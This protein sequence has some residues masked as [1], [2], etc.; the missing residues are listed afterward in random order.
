MQLQALGELFARLDELSASTTHTARAID[1]QREAIEVARDTGDM[2]TESFALG[3]LGRLAERFGELE[4]GLAYTRLAVDRAEKSGTLDGLYRWQWQAARLLEALDQSSRALAA[5][6]QAI[7]TLELVRPALARG[8]AGSFQKEVAP[9]FFGMADLLLKDHEKAPHGVDAQTNL[10]QVRNTVER[11]KVAEIRDY[12]AEDCVIA[13]EEAATLD[14]VSPDA[15]VV[16]PIL[17]DDR[18]EILTSYGEQI[19]RHS[20]A[21]SRAELT[22]AVNAF[23]RSLVLRNQQT[24]RET[25]Q[26]LY[27]LLLGQQIAAL[28]EAGVDTLIFVPDGPLRTVPPAA[29]WDGKRFLI[30]DFAVATTLGLTLTSPQP[31]VSESATILAGGLTQSVEGFSALPAVAN[32]LDR[33][34]SLFPGVEFRDEQFRI[35]PVTQQLSEG[36]YSIVHIATH[37]KF[38]SDYRDSFL[39][40]FDGRMTMDMLESSVGLRRYLNDPVELLMLSACET[41]VGDERAALG[42]AGVALKAGAR[43][44]IATLWAIDDEATATVVGSFYEELKLPGVT[45][46]E[47]LRRA[48]LR[49]LGDPQFR[50]PAAWSPFL[51]IGN[52][53]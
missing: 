20:H 30:E 24:Y 32:E 7:D 36:S 34:D 42:L 40:T 10:A 41:A 2:R 15:A 18:L 45:K 4:K 38:S 9:V 50:H 37:G 33:I 5:Y 51:L 14:R 28:R 21:I 39:L 23:R 12:F 47:A 43:S 44:A 25:G 19:S 3:N 53:L 46:A 52:W 26:R 8:D 49:A 13:E 27:D 29:L 6:Q 1:A 17:F 35:R 31:I 22:A 16:Y 11:F 48:Q